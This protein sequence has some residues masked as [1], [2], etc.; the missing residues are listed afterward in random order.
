GGAYT[1][2]GLPRDANFY[3]KLTATGYVPTY[4]GPVN[5][6]GDIS[7]IN[8][9]LFTAEEMLGYGVTAGNGML[10]CKVVDPSLNP[11]SGATVLL[12]S[13]KQA[14]Y[15]VVYSGGGSATNETGKFKVPDILPGDVVKIEVTKAGYAFAPAYLDGFTSAVTGRYIAGAPPSNSVS[16]TISYSGSQTGSFRL[17]LWSADMMGSYYQELTLTGGSFTFNNVPNGRY[18]LSAYRDSNNDSQYTA[19]EAYGY[20]QDTSGPQVITINGANVNIGAVTVADPSSGSTGASVSINA[21]IGGLRGY[22]V[23]FRSGDFLGRDSL[24][25]GI[26]PAFVLDVDLTAGLHTY[27]VTV[28]QHDYTGMPVPAG[29]YDFYFMTGDLESGPDKGVIQ[30][31]QTGVAIGKGAVTAIPASGSIPFNAGGSVSGTITSSFGA[32]RPLDR[33]SVYLTEDSTG[34][35]LRAWGSTNANGQFQ[36]DHVPAGAYW[37]QLAYAG[38]NAFSPITVTVTDGGASS[39]PV[40][41]TVLTPT[42][43][44]A[45]IVGTLIPFGPD[46]DSRIMLKQGETVIANVAPSTTD[47]SYSISDLVPGSYTLIGSARGYT[48]GQFSVSVTAGQALTQDF[49]LNGTKDV[50]VNGLNWLLAHQRADGS[51]DDNLSGNADQFVFGWTGYTGLTLLAVLENPKYNTSTSPDYLGVDLLGQ[52]HDALYGVI[53]ATPKNGIKQYFEST[54]HAAD[55]PS[56]GWNDIGALYND[57]IAWASVAA[58]PVALEK[59]IAL[60]M[61]LSDPKVTGAIQFL[62]GAQITAAKASNPIFA[63]GWRYNPENTDTDNWETAWVIMALMKAGVNPSVQAV[64]D[65]LAH[66]RRSQITEG[67]GAGLFSYQPNDTSG[68]G[69][70]GTS[71]ASIL[72]LNF[73]GAPN[74]DADVN[75]F[76]QWVKNNGGFNGYDRWADAYWWSMFPWA[77]ILYDDPAT[78]GPVK[79]YYETLELTWKMAD[80]IILRQKPDGSWSN[81]NFSSGGS[82]SGNAVMYTA[83]A[84]MAIAPY[85]GLTPRPDETTLSGTVKNPAEA[86]LQ[87]AKVEALLDGVVRASTVTNGSGVY[88]LSVPQNY[89]YTVRVTAAGYV[90]SAIT[91]ANVGTGG[92]ANQDIA[93]LATDVDTAQPTISD[94]TPANGSTVP[95]GKPAI[96]AVV[97]DLGSR[98]NTPSGIDPATISMKLDGNAVNA[99]YNASTGVVSFTP[100]YDLSNATHTV[101]VDVYDYAGDGAQ[102][103]WSFIY[104]A[105]LSYTP[106]VY[107]VHSSSGYNTY[108]DFTIGTNFTGTLPD[109]IT[110]INVT[111][112]GGT[113]I[114]TRPNFLYYPEF[115]EFLVKLPGQPALGEYRFEVT[116]LSQT[117]TGTD[118]QSVN[119][120]IPVPDK[121]AFTYTPGENPTFSWGAVDYA[122]TPLYYRLIINNMAG[123]RVYSSTRVLGMLSHTVPVGTLQTD[124]SY[125]FQVRVDDAASG[126]LL[127]NESRS[128]YVTFSLTPI[129]YTGY[130]ADSQSPSQI[131]V[132][133]TV[134]Q[135][136][137]PTNFATTDATGLYTLGNLKAGLPFYLKISK[138]DSYAPCYSAEMT[139]TANRVDPRDRAFTLFPSSRLGSGTGN[140]NVDAGKGIIRAYVRDRIDGYVGGAVVTATGVLQATYPVCYDDNCTPSL[141]VTKDKDGAGRYVIKNVLNGDTVTVTATKAGWTF[142]T[143]V[144]HTVAGGVSQGRLTGQGPVSLALTVNTRGPDWTSIQGALAQVVGFPAVSAVTGADGR[145]TLT[146]LPP[147][148]SIP[149]AISKEGYVNG[150]GLFSATGVSTWS[151]PLYTQAD[152]NTWGVREG[153]GLIYGRAINN[154]D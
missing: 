24:Q 43:T 150:Y 88:T 21:A 97:T 106:M 108:L 79:K 66:I 9:T 80:D 35:I 68:Y 33:V 53:G 102:A 107:N 41:N 132:G 26:Q 74:T 20:Y 103:S 49:T 65:G 148:T 75:R 63:G 105:G 129:S 37:L 118:N 19:G 91:T 86:G 3:N 6:S 45:T 61:P 84:L 123:N 120:N 76:F 99:S 93:Y 83:S 12:T 59:L 46:V 28:M 69:P 143:R 144:Y 130:V 62:L 4:A 48:P 121:G 32:H 139:Y 133:A 39:I 51:F 90:R 77:A 17:M 142:N 125:Q 104:T 111:G 124:Q 5:L 92:L 42:Q 18:F 141:T 101:I 38:Y 134:E 126:N 56:T 127:Q 58:T 138:D 151:V 119:R 44:P 36:F 140:W 114:A 95:T 1:F 64:V 14:S 52:I 31:V 29:N 98:G 85:A 87:N 16:G 81:P 113:V 82:N 30:Y 13:K 109:A 115:R 57:T 110:A 50:I 147:N 70:L 137:L 11:L 23:F 153:A 94:L 136:G 54:Y 8:I 27:P 7:G 128:D 117:T 71:A 154:A 100:Q 78:A 15:S 152:L 40:E 135:G 122:E 25:S 72:A 112:P 116:G 89:A 60:G 22:L 10:T 47:G 131:V 149:F 67:G 96:S 55:D 145:A 73:A 34:Q 2:S 146:G